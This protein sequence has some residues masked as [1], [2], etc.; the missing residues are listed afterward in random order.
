M[1]RDRRGVS[2]VEFALLAPVMLTLLIGGNE[3][4]QALTIYRK[5]SHTGSALGD[6]V[7]QV[8]SI[9]TAEMSNILAASTSI[10]TPY[11]ASGVR[12][13]V[14]AV[15][16]TTANGFKV[17]WSVGQNATAWTQCSTPPI[18]IPSGL[19]SDGQQIVVTSVSY[20]YVSTFSTFMQDIL[21]AT[22]L[23]LSDVS[24]LRPRVS[25]K[26]TYSSQCAT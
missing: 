7:S 3:L 2:A 8:S 5:V 1:V 18:T 19:I 6:L 20:T 23:T 17:S 26:I 24:Y 12:L 15:N 16:Y 11:D 22:S 21:G 25:T 13:V 10:M 14:S 9:T 4:S